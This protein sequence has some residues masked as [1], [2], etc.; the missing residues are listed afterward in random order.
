VLTGAAH[1]G[2]ST[3]RLARHNGDV[4]GIGK[5][6]PARWNLRMA[7]LRKGTYFPGFLDDLVNAMGMSGIFP[8]EDA[9]TRLIG[10]LLLEQNDDWAVQDPKTHAACQLA[11]TKRPLRLG[12]SRMTS[13]SWPSGER[14]S[15]LK[16]PLTPSK[17]LICV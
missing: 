16:R 6:G 11:F 10:A 9:I 3:P 2:K 13:T 14:A 7:R 8:N 12:M 5:R 15:T 4:T 1:G 17:S